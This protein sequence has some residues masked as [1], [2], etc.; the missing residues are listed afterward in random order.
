[1]KVESNGGII[2]TGK[3]EELVERPLPLP[4]CAPKSR[5]ERPGREDGP[6]GERSNSA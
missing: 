2:L 6:P 5:T 4:L 3:S 1:M